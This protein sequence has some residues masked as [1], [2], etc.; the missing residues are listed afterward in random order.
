MKIINVIVVGMS[1]GKQVVE[2]MRLSQDVES[3]VN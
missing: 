3:M 2:R 1:Q